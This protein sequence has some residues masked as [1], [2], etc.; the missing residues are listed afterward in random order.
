MGL[1]VALIEPRI[2]PNT[3]NIARLCAATGATLHLVG[4]LGFS[5]DDQQLKR[6]GLDYWQHVD[7]W[8]H[9]H[10]R[11]F[12]S[13]VSR[14]RCFYFSKHAERSYHDAPYESNSVLVFGSETKGMPE[15][16][17]EKYPDR[18]FRIPMKNAVRSLNLANAAAIVLYDAVRQMGIKLDGA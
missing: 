4:E 11:D 6:A 13:A 10:W 16:I 15:R 14:D 18:L 7:L 8:I 17:R 5:L 12:R 3:G 2:P 9:P 1:A